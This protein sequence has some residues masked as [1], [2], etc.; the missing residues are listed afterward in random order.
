MHRL[1]YVDTKHKYCFIHDDFFLVFIA[2]FVKSQERI[3]S[4]FIHKTVKFSFT[5][6]SLK[7]KEKNNLNETECWIKLPWPSHSLPILMTTSPGWPGATW[8]FWKIL[9]LN[10]KNIKLK[11]QGLMRVLIEMMI[12]SDFDPKVWL[13]DLS[14]GGEGGLLLPSGVVLPPLVLSPHLQGLLGLTLNETLF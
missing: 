2:F 8:M 10:N 3:H 7:Q 5:R 1:H 6:S 12:D 13:A 11:I 14:A 4:Y 9:I